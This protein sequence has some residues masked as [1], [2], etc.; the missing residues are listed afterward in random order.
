MTIILNPR[1]QDAGASPGQANHWTIRSFTSRRSIAGF[2]P[3]PET[4]WDGFERWFARLESRPAI[5]FTRF[6]FEGMSSEDFENAWNNS[7]YLRDLLPAMKARSTM[8]DFNVL[9]AVF[10]WSELD[11][12][13]EKVSE[14]FESGWRSNESSARSW[15]DV[16]SSPA[17]FNG[18]SSTVESFEDGSWPLL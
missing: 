13:D 9:S 5:S 2:G 14:T 3:A 7:V 16:P 1:F 18:G 8:S 10:N 15:D 12:A 17:R 6:Y 11:V 4:A